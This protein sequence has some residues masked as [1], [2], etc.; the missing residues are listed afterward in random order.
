MATHL[1][2][3]STAFLSSWMHYNSFSLSRSLPKKLL[4]F[5]CFTSFVAVLAG[6]AVVLGVDVV[7]AVVGPTVLLVGVPPVAIAFAGASGEMGLSSPF[8]AVVA[9][10]IGASADG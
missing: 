8:S 10:V 3:T 2:A 7:P 1:E 4:R 9:F 6:E 5:L